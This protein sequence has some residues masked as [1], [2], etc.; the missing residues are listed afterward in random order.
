MGLE[1]DARAVRKAD[2]ADHAVY[3]LPLEHHAH[4]QQRLGRGPL[5]AGQFGENLIAAALTEDRVRVGDVLR[6]GTAT[7]QVTLPR[8][9]CRKLDARMNARFSGAFLRSRRTGYYLRVLHP[10]QVCVGDAIE[11]VD[12]DAASPTMDD[13]I[14]ISQLDYWDVEGL[15]QLLGARGLGPHFRELL[16]DKLDRAGRADGWLGLRELEIVARQR[17]ADG[18]EVL[19]LRCARGRPLPPGRAGQ[20]LTLSL[21]A[22][23]D[24]G[25]LRCTLPLR[26][27]SGGH[28]GYRVG[29]D[30]DSGGAAAR[31]LLAA[32][33]TGDRVRAE[34]PRG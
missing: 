16:Q 6:C 31:T 26:V 10:G 7:L 9:P 11:V 15:R 24:S 29:L 12:S 32:L 27:A 23:D 20:R 28:E 17:S 5:P 25:P 34:A 22:A 2:A 21:R 14:R 8:I 13:F 3:L 19:Q 33:T 30:P 4:W 1:G 18:A